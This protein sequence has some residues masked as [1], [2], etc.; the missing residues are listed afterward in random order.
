MPEVQRVRRDRKL[1]DEEARRYAEIAAEAEA[2]IP[3]VR[4]RMK[5]DGFYGHSTLEDVREV[6]RL[7]AFLR[8]ERERLG[9]DL[10]EVSKRSGVKPEAL[11]ALEEGRLNDTYISLL[12]RYSRAL[13]KSLMLGLRQVESA[14]APAP[15]AETKQ[16]A[17]VPA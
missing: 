7:G 3:E 12:S 2:E 6:M 13:G 9:L 14:P 16:L 11:Q 5:K 4:R 15:P 8:T 1:T 10:A 17:E